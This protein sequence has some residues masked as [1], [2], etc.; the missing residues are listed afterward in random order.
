MGE[1]SDARDETDRPEPDQPTE[2][3]GLMDSRASAHGTPVD[4]GV[5]LD[6]EDD[7]EAETRVGSLPLPTDGSPSAASTG[8]YVVRR[9]IARGGMGAIYKVRDKDLRRS[10]AMKVI[11]GG[12]SGHREPGEPVSPE[13][14]NRF[15]EEAQITAQLAHP[16]VVP[17]HELGVDRTGRIYFTMS[18]VRGDTLSTII[19]RTR[20]G[21]DGWTTSRA[22]QVILRVC[23]TMAFAHSKGVIHR[24]IKPANIMVGRFGET[25]VMDWGLAKVLGRPDSHDIRLK[26]VDP[27]TFSNIETIRSRGGRPAGHQASGTPNRRI[28]L[29][30]PRDRCSGHHERDPAERHLDALALPGVEVLRWGSAPDCSTAASGS[31]SASNGSTTRAR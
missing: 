3:D 4:P 26:Q 25:Y 1:S 2:S 17:V 22:L 18:L 15:L 14:L 28:A 13:F 5:N 6:P 21:R 8:R 9:E 31:S 23:E 27:S 30:Q 12:E 29:R 24:D 16:G 7:A 11:L 20:A 10:L 19:R